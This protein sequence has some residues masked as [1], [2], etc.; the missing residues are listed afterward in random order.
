MARASQ[1]RAQSSGTRSS[2]S[3]RTQASGM[4]RKLENSLIGKFREA[5]RS[6]W[7]AHQSGQQADA[8]P[9]SS[10]ITASSGRATRG[11]AATTGASRRR[12]A[13]I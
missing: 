5:L 12:N 10:R 3:T 13:A 11:K 7:S 1:P 2:G 9:Q 8:A 6:E 4:P